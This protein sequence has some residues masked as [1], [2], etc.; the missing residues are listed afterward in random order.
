MEELLVTLIEVPATWSWRPIFSVPQIVV[1][2]MCLVV[3]AG[4]AYYRSTARRFAGLSLLLIRLI[5]IVALIIILLGPSAIRGHDRHERPSPLAVVVDLSES[6]ETRDCNAGTS[7]LALAK[8]NWLNSRFLSRLRSESDVT[9]YGFGERLVT[10]DAEPLL[11]MEL[12]DVDRQVT[13]V[14]RSLT[15]VLSRFSFSTAENPSIL[16]LTD[17]HD[18]E[19]AS[20]NAA[21]ALAVARGVAVHTVAFGSAQNSSDL[22]LLATPL[23]PYLLPGEPGAIL[24]KVYQFG[25]PDAETILR[26]EDGQRT[27][28][29]PVAFQGRP[30]VE[31]QLEVA[32]AGPGQHEYQLSIDAVEGDVE[33]RNNR[34][35]VF[36]E[37][38]DRR[39][40]VLALEGQPYWDSKFLAQSLRKDERIELTQITQIS[41]DSRETIVS[42]AA[43]DAVRVPTTAAEWAAYDVVVLGRDVQKLVAAEGAGQLKR[44]VV[45]QGGHVVF[46]RGRC[47]DPQDAG[48]DRWQAS[49]RTIEPVVWGPVVDEDFMLRP[50]SGSL[51]HTWLAAAKTSTDAG[52]RLARLPGLESLQGA[53]RVKSGAIALVDAV[54]LDQSAVWP[55]VVTMHAGRGQV[56]GLLGNGSWRWSLRPPDETNGVG[57]YDEF[58]SNMVRWLVLGGDFQPGEQVSLR[59]SRQ[60][61]QVGETLAIDLSFKNAAALQADWRV[62]WI[63]ADGQTRDVDFRKLAGQLPRLRSE[64]RPEMSG[65]HQIRLHTPTSS[66][67]TQVRKF[68]AF[69]I[70]LERLDPSARPERLRRCAERTRGGFFA[71]DRPDEF[72]EVLERRAL[73]QQIPTEPEYVWDHWVVMIVLLIWLGGDWILRRS[74]GL[75]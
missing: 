39:I 57:F 48:G 61:V 73:A 6:M 70:N 75:L 24:V 52:E 64:I 28:Q 10:L 9:L 32:R 74:A 21:S 12:V 37:V 42:R 66:T 56:V 45:E 15:N 35:T 50:T 7:R 29:I 38:R 69:D 72:L 1:L 20:L 30:V 41:P 67:A 62:E 44:F 60:S 19:D 25:L 36:C 14:E 49:L 26:F 8:E 47:Y 53:R 68:N 27:R 22:A 31:L 11:D 59:L 40:K 16:L 65:V 4:L 2:A 46:C 51:D 23:Q 54:S 33:P 71:P 3:L 43:A 17:G 5:G 55:V 13:H 58:W 63:G 34:Q 18:T